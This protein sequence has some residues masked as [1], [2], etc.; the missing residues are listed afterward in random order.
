[1]KAIRRFLQVTD[2]I[3]LPNFLAFCPSGWL[4][5]CL[6]IPQ[7]FLH[8]RG[9]LWA[10]AASLFSFC[11]SFDVLKQ[12]EEERIDTKRRISKETWRIEEAEWLKMS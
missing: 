5:A 11:S 2:N 12:V 7:W 10:E 6:Q 9:F 4:A 8:I 1:M 3:F